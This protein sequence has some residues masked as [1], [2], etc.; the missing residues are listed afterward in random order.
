MKQNKESI[1]ERIIKAYINCDYEKARRLEVEYFSSRG[2]KAIESRV[3]RIRNTTRQQFGLV[4][5]SH[6]IPDNIQ[7]C[8]S[9]L[10]SIPSVWDYEE[11]R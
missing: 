2:T 1:E 11:L 3:S 4:S 10:A 8:K 7:N 5:V 6:K 9:Y